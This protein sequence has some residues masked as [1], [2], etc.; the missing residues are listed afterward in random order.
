MGG[1]SVLP[2]REECY[3]PLPRLDPT[4]CMAIPMAQCHSKIDNYRCRQVIYVGTRLVGLVRPRSID[5][6]R[7]LIRKD[8]SCNSKAKKD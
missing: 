8:R 1:K 7:K 5:S 4:L 6:V 3:F 2:Q